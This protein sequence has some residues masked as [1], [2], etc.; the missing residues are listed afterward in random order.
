MAFGPG[1]WREEGPE[2]AGLPGNAR[3]QSTLGAWGL[4]C[5]EAAGAL[6]T[7]GLLHCRPPSQG[8]AARRKPPGTWFPRL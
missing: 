4:P 5:C 6:G 8:P 3:N 7:T 1:L 2:A